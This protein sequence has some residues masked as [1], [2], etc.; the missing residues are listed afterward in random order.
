M[1]LNTSGAKGTFASPNVGTGITVI[2]SGLMLGGAD[3]VNYTLT[4]PT[5]TANIMPAALDVNGITASSKTYNGTTAAA[6]DTSGAM[7]RA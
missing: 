7:L 5:T 3:A 6:L 4:E 2:V 1:T